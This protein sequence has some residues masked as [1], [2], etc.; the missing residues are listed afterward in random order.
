MVYA[1]ILSVKT[2][3][4]GGYAVMLR[5][6]I[7]PLAIGCFLLTDYDSTVTIDGMTEHAIVR[8][9]RNFD[10]TWQITN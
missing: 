3:F 2:S 5:K 4:F 8:A 10:G 6:I 9:C 7:A 1:V